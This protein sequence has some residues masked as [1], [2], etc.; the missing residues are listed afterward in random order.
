MLLAVPNFSEGRDERVVDAL[1]STLAGL[2]GVDAGGLLAGGIEPDQRADV[3]RPDAG[4]KAAVAAHVDALDRDRG[5]R[6]QQLVEFPRVAVEGDDG[7]VVLGVGVAVEQ[8]ALAVE[9]RANRR[10]H[11]GVAA[12]G[13]VGDS[14]QGQGRKAIQPAANRS[15]ADVGTALAAATIASPP[16]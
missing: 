11:R 15:G 14:E 3:Q 16:E 7:A 1:E 10:D 12:L 8:A 9:R 4:M 13:E 2:A 6:R 5:S